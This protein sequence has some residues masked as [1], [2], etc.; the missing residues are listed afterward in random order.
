[1]RRL[2]LIAVFSVA[3]GLTSAQAVPGIGNLGPI[4]DTELAS[5]AQMAGPYSEGRT[6]SYFDVRAAAPFVE[7]ALTKEPTT[8]SFINLI[9]RA[10]GVAAAGLLATIAAVGLKSLWVQ[11]PIRY[12]DREGPA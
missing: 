5:N 7:A 6:V 12:F 10:L 11:H 1:M 4:S 8:K 3:F 9:W 2:L